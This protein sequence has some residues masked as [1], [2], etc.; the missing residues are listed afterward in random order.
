M[1]LKIES[2]GTIHASKIA[3]LVKRNIGSLSYYGDTLTIDLDFRHPDDFR[4]MHRL[5]IPFSKR[6]A[7]QVQ[8]IAEQHRGEI[9]TISTK[10]K[11]VQINGI[12][13]A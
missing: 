13:I 6:Q 2:S 3:E 8:K 12:K 9:L 4:I 1:K 5:A 7:E 10:G 11:E